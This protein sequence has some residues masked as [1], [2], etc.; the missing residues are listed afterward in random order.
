MVEQAVE[1]GGDR[2]GVAEQL[3]PVLDGPVGFASAV[4]AAQQGRRHRGAVLAGQLERLG[5][6]SFSFRPHAPSMS[7]LRPDAYA[8]RPAALRMRT[9]RGSGPFSTSCQGDRLLLT[10]DRD[11]R[12]W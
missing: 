6:D 10:A 2:G 11:R 7:R 1:Q 5:P 4:E 3:A 8:A 9:T 12:T